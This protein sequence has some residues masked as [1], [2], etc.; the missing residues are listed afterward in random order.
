M[1]LYAAASGLSIG[2]F[3]PFVQI[4]FAPPAG[5]PAPAPQTVPGASGTA[6]RTLLSQAKWGNLDRWPAFLRRPLEVWL[7]GRPPLAA[8][9][10]F[11]VLLLFVFL[12]KNVLDYLGSFL[13]I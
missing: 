6:E 10:R 8:L 2:L 11:C 12:V 9:G 5:T 1:A 7:F 3:S 4:V 13:M